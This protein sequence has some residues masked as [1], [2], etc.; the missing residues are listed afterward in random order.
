MPPWTKTLHAK[1]QV[2]RTNKAYSVI[3]CSPGESV[4][5]HC[6]DENSQHKDVQWQRTDIQET[7]NPVNVIKDQRY[8]DRVQIHGNLSLSINRL[9]VDDTGSYWCNSVKQ[10]DLIIEGC[11]LSANEAS[12]SISRYSGESVF[13]SCLVKCSARYNPDKIRWKLPN[14]REINQTTNSTELYPLYQGRFHMFGKNTGNFSLLISNLTEKYEGLY[15]CWINENQHKSFNLTVK[16]C[17]LSETE[18]EPETK[19]PGDSVLLSC[20][21]KDPKSKPE[22]F[23]WTQGTEVSN[24]TLR[25]RARVHMFNKTTPSNLSLLISNLTEDDQGTYICTVNNK[26]STRTSLTVKGCVLSKHPNTI[27]SYPGESVTLPCSCEDPKTKPK[28]VEWKLAAVNETLVSDSKDV[29]GRFQILRDSPHNLSLRISNLT[30]ADGGLYECTVNGKQ[31]R[32]IN[33]TVTDFSKSRLR[34]SLMFLIC[35]LLT[36]FI[37]WRFTQAKKG[38]RG[39]RVTQRPDHQDDVTYSTVMKIN[40][41][42]PA[43]NQ[44]QDDVTYSSIKHIKE[45]K[46]TCRKEE[47]VV[48]ST[49]ADVS[50]GRSAQ[51]D[52][53]YSSVVCSKS[54][55][56]RSLQMNTEEAVVYASVQKDKT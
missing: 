35:L 29:S 37:C 36:G 16:G 54:H 45:G 44:Q 41:G 51:D 8:K 13:L 18:R 15:S 6:R 11:S 47:E 31:S 43:E 3:S 5:L 27:I 56:P 2:D 50:N 12:E 1:F 4:L 17:T 19:Y 39:T 52:V 46:R 26:T 23:K 32:S 20:S 48:Y 30:E 49:M 55:K 34:Y 42:K 21:C 40:R 9:T 28:H 38:R 10:V 25:Y 53:T 22:S 14:N 33:L 24:E 7:Q